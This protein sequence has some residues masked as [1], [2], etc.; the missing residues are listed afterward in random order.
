MK[1]E[2]L[3]FIK[4]GKTRFLTYCL[5]NSVGKRYVFTCKTE[6]ELSAG[7]GGGR[8]VLPYMSSDVPLDGVAFSRVDYNGAAFST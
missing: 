3:K 1:H 7:G 4:G 2:G 8:M 6:N 5:S